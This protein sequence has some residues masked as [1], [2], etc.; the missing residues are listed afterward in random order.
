[1]KNK[2]IIVGVIFSVLFVG[3]LS[4]YAL[5]NNKIKYTKIETNYL[6]NEFQSLKVQNEAL[7]KINYQLLQTNAEVDDKLNQLKITSN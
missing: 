7:R 3:S 5:N 2:N 6:K 1:M 4:F